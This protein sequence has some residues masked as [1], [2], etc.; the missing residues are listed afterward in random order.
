MSKGNTA[1]ARSIAR[2]DAIQMARASRLKIASMALQIMAD[3][4]ARM[5]APMVATTKGKAAHARRA[6]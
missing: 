3:A 2:L 1:H 5:T 6:A 4:N